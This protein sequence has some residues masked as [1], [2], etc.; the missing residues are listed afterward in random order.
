[1]DH[2]ISTEMTLAH[3]LASVFDFCSD[4]SNLEAITPPEH[5]FAYREERVRALLET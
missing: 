5:R 1:M 2:R 3:P 4:A